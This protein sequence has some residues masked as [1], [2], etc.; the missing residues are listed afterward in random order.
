MPKRI[1][2]LILIDLE[3]HDIYMFPKSCGQ[4]SQ[5]E[6]FQTLVLDFNPQTNPRL[7]LVISI[8]E[9]LQIVLRDARQL[10]DL[11]IHFPGNVQGHALHDIFDR[12]SS[13]K[14]T[15]LDLK[16]V[17][18]T[19]EVLQKI[20][21]RNASSLRALCLDNVRLA[22]GASSTIEKIVSSLPRSVRIDR[23]SAV[24]RNQ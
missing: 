3:L 7:I 8:A 16:N 13:S 23:K 21:A 11:R 15:R 20:I 17:V 9:R 10:R 24:S 1:R 22:P 12:I 6:N 5:L 2:E 4:R 18:F 19:W 14:L